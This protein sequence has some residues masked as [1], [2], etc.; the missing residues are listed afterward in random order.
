MTKILDFNL[1][2]SHQCFYILLE[3]SMLYIHFTP[4]G[5]FDNSFMLLELTSL[6]VQFDGV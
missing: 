1:Q 6:K 5:C 3:S 2:T 4:N